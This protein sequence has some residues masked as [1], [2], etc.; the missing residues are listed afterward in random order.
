VTQAVGVFGDYVSMQPRARILG[1]L[2]VAAALMSWVG[3]GF[4]LADFRLLGDE[5]EGIAVASTRKAAHRAAGEVILVFQ[6]VLLS[7]A[8]VAFVEWLYQSRINLRAFGV[9]RLRYSRSWV[10]GGFLIPALNLVRPYQV[11]REVWQASDPRTRDP[12]AWNEVPTG[13][14]LP[15]WWSTFVTWALLALLALGMEMGAGLDPDK[16]RVA[17]GI[18][19][20]ADVAAA[21]GVSLAYFVV[22]HISRTQDQKWDLARPG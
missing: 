8:A 12:F 6:I 4:D 9:R 21:V 18:T 11:I 20:V 15:L 5:T 13:R 19:L 22:D 17:R 7:V 3:V 1:G 16:L 2:L 14:L 10:L